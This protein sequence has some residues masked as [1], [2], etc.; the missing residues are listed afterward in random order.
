M[1][2]KTPEH[3]KDNTSLV[4]MFQRD[5]AENPNWMLE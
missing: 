3:L 5:I 4:W 2:R 1:I